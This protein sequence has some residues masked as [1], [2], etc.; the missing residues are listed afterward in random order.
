MFRRFMDDQTVARSMEAAPSQ[1][2]YGVAPWCDAACILA[3]IRRQRRKRLVYVVPARPPLAH[4]RNSQD[5]MNA[6][7]FH[8]WSSCQLAR[9]RRSGIALEI[10]L[11]IA[12]SSQPQNGCLG[13][14][15]NRAGGMLPAALPPTTCT[16]SLPNA[17]AL[18]DRMEIEFDASSGGLIQQ[19][20]TKSNDE[21]ES[22]MTRTP[23]AAIRR[24][25]APPKPC[26]SAPRVSIGARWHHALNRARRKRRSWTGE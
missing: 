6:P 19:P 9:G 13:S 10:A 7:I 12:V 25:S 5:L 20:A 8:E 17:N 15:Y 26:G 1:E 4:A 18:F 23:G 16:V 24:R 14:A 11:C 3:P 21:E 2:T 22:R